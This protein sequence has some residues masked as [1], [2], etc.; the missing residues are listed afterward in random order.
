MKSS[1]TSD[2]RIIHLRY[3]QLQ[4]KNTENKPK[5]E[6][7]YKRN[8]YVAIYINVQE[9]RYQLKYKNCF[10][11]LNKKYHKCFFRK[12]AVHILQHP[13]ILTPGMCRIKW[14]SNANYQ[15]MESSYETNNL[16]NEK[17]KTYK[18]NSLFKVRNVIINVLK[19]YFHICRKY[20]SPNFALK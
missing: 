13:C 1:Q 10:Y 14:Y 16:F 2:S 6:A 12:E 7:K 18:K 20:V 3:Y 15:M 19:S 8:N 11:L 9:K 4:S 17:Y 5:M